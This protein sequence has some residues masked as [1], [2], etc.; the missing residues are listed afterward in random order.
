M[1]SVERLAFSPTEV[2]E[3]LGVSRAWVYRR[4]D[5]GTIPSTKVG[6]RRLITRA[7]LDRLLGAETP[8]VSQRLFV[9]GGALYMVNV[10]DGTVT[11][12]AEGE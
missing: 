1:A 11:L 8:G 10:D 9:K 4:I 7:T 5:D 6:G 3:A 2:A 12:V